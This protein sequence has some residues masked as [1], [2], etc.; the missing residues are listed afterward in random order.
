MLK[1]LI[2]DRYMKSYAC[3]LIIKKML[4]REFNWNVTEDELVFLVI[5][6]ERITKEHA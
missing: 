6:I 1:E 4:K 2:Q 3:G 5:H